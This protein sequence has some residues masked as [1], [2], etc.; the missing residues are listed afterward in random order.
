LTG[1]RGAVRR[2]GPHGVVAWME[3]D[4]R[5][6]CAW[7]RL[8]QLGRRGVVGDRP[9]ERS[10]VLFDGS[11][12][13]VVVGLGCGVMERRGAA[14]DLAA[15]VRECTGYS[16]GGIRREVN[17]SAWR[18][19]ATRA[20][21]WGARGAAATH[22]IGSGGALARSGQRGQNTTGLTRCRTARGRK[23]PGWLNPIGSAL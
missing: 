5:Q 23:T 16:S 15:G 9:E 18:A 22:G 3:E 10:V 20:I 7:R 19:R 8:R 14:E 2:W 12:G 21:A 11:V 13:N 1:R 4:R 6:R 17:S